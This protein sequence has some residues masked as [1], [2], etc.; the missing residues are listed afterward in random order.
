MFCFQMYT[1]IARIENL[2]LRGMNITKLWEDGVSIPPCRWNLKE[3]IV[4]ECKN[5][6]YLLSSTM[7][8]SLVQLKRLA[9]NRCEEMEEVVAFREEP[10]NVSLLFPNLQYLRLEELPKLKKFCGGDCVE[11]PLL[12]ELIILN[13]PE[14]RVLCTNSMSMLTTVNKKQLEEL[15]SVAYKQPLFKHKVIFL[16]S[17]IPLFSIT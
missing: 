8:G 7:C 15:D 13:C 10:A 2:E 5:L 3:L 17:Y 11:F 12:S 14:L 6:K 1:K 4:K 16:F 9:I